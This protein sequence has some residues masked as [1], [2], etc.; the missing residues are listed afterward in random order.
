M[1]KMSLSIT[2]KKKQKPT[3]PPTKQTANNEAH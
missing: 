2:L 1:V 3:K